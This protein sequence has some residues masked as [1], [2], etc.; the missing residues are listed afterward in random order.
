MVVRR[1]ALISDNYWL[2]DLCFSLLIGKMG[3]I[4]YDSRVIVM[5]SRTS[6]SAVIIT[7]PRCAAVGRLTSRLFLICPH[8][9]LCA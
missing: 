5:V 7:L 8:A 2:S 9:P 1:W 4:T 6:P 3:K